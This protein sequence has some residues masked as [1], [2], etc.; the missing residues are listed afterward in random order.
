MDES[1]QLKKLLGNDLMT[2]AVSQG[3]DVTHVNRVDHGAV[4][5]DQGL[6]RLDMKDFLQVSQIASFLT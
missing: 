6:R 2:W 4:S 5:A 1:I 3:V